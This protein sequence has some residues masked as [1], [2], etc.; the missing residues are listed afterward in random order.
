MRNYQY[1]HGRRAHHGKRHGRR[2][3]RG[4]GRPMKDI[5]IEDLPKIKKIVPEPKLQE[6]PIIMTIAEFEAL[7]LVDLLDHN[8]ED[9]GREMNIS[10]TAIWRLI[11]S[12]RRKLV[13]MLIEGREI[14]FNE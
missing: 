7:R 5:I 10:R 3:Q 4:R 9:A 13:T 14:I 1:K 12:G 8:Q 6:E 11:N 2:E